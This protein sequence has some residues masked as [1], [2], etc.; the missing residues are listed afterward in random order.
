MGSK[1][2]YQ[3]P[4]L[5]E[6]LASRMLFSYTP[7]A[8]CT[9]LLLDLKSDR[10][11]TMSDPFDEDETE[12]KTRA[13][14]PVSTSP[15]DQGILH[16]MFVFRFKLIQFINSIHNHFMT[17]VSATNHCTLKQNSLLNGHL[18]CMYSLCIG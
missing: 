18:L 4:I 8:D 6:V 13:T 12:S 16:K 2:N 3:L 1:S 15:P 7:V 14:D 11:Q 10:Q 9:L 5:C 17:R